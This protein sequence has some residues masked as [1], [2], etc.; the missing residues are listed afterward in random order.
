ML[1]CA[2][3]AAGSEEAQLGRPDK[4]GRSTRTALSGQEQASNSLEWLYEGHTSMIFNVAQLMKSPV[5]TSRTEEIEP[6]T[7]DLGTTEATLAG[8]VTGRVRM[9]RMNQGIL[10][11]GQVEADAHL[12]CARCLRPFIHHLGFK[13]EEQ[14]YPT[15][16]I[17][18][19]IALPPIEDDSV[20]FP[21]DQYHQIDLSEAIRQN[22]L[23]ALPMSPRC[24]EDC[25]GLC[26]QCG[27]D[28]NEGPCSCEPL[29]DERWSALQ[30]LLESTGTSLTN[31]NL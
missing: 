26:P 20:I 30:D 17:V 8:P 28:L 23:L 3:A 7:I 12:Q 25:A 9:R 2:R 6:D 11:D 18:T 4:P 10:V 5:G 16:D 15:I 24:R 19:G 21:I 1:P 13:L 14:F 22:L 29:V 31:G 27:K